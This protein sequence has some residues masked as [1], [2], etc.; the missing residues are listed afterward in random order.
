M[1]KN[2]DNVRDNISS[3]MTYDSYTLFRVALFWFTQVENFGFVSLCIN[4]EQF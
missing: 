1:S 2:Q 4:D 3:I